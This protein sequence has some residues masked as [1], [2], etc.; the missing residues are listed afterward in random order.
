MSQAQYSDVIYSLIKEA[1]LKKPAHVFEQLLLKVKDSKSEDKSLDVL[2][3]ITF[4]DIGKINF[5][6]LK[7]GCELFV[8]FSAFY[9]FFPEELKQLDV[10]MQ[11]KLTVDLSW[12]KK[13]VED[14]I[15]R[16][17]LLNRP[18][19]ERRA[20]R[21]AE[22]QKNTDVDRARN[23]LLKESDKDHRAKVFLLLQQGPKIGVDDKK[24][25]VTTAV[26]ATETASIQKMFEKMR[27]EPDYYLRYLPGEK[28]IDYYR[29]F[30][31]SKKPNETLHMNAEIKKMIEENILRDLSNIKIDDHD[32]EDIAIIYSNMTKLIPFLDAQSKFCRE[33]IKH[34]LEV[35]NNA[36]FDDHRNFYILQSLYP[37]LNSED[38]KSMIDKTIALLQSS[39]D[40][41]K[42]Y[43]GI[44]L[45]LDCLRFAESA[46]KKDEIINAIVSQV[47]SAIAIDN[48]NIGRPKQIQFIS[49][50]MW[51]LQSL[52]C[53][54]GFTIK[55]TDGSREYTGADGVTIARKYLQYLTPD[56]GYGQNHFQHYLTDDYLK[57]SVSVQF[58]K[59]SNRSRGR[60]L[61]SCF[62]GCF[63]KSEDLLGKDAKHELRK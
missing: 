54:H 3:K 4:K 15:K 62:T 8:L 48:D 30:L 58:Y 47:K 44:L 26:A 6:G 22:L 33:A 60:G 28:L 10:A 7:D 57:D 19:E 31:Q 1:N 56:S 41:D 29:E 24:E 42:K 61:F 27:G 40:R 59:K 18:L 36:N 37:Y 23:S 34:V 9:S 45:L 51:C 5:Q 43:N 38:K 20:R 53:E 50:G 2:Q 12:V 52:P 63:D 35:I 11:K 39:H 49:M 46:N 55:Y 25:V 21:K 16:I 13:H 14:E 17:E 32:N